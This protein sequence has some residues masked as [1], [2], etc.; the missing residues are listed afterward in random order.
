MIGQSAPALWESVPRRFGRPGGCMA[1]LTQLLAD[2]VRINS[3]NPDLVADG[4]G[5]REIAQY[6]A[7]WAEGQGL[8]AHLVEPAPGRPSVVVVA[9]GTGGGKSLMLN[10]HVDTVGVA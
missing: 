3:T 10:G 6:I 5:E 8:E 7:A 4:A 9:R 1:N 2:L